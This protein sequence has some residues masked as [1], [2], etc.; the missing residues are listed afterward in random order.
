[1][2]HTSN[3]PLSCHRF[4][5]LQLLHDRHSLFH[6]WRMEKQLSVWSTSSVREVRR[7]SQ[8]VESIRDSAHRLQMQEAFCWAKLVYAAGLWSCCLPVWAAIELILKW[9]RGRYYTGMHFLRRPQAPPPPGG[10]ATC[11]LPQA[12]GLI[13]C[14]PGRNTGYFALEFTEKSA[15][16]CAPVKGLKP[17]AP[18]SLG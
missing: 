4:C 14:K 3:S 13:S 15:G 2:E 7:C 18:P 5:L 1:M 9:R 17:P 16:G 12:Y 11:R 6:T 10:L 8:K